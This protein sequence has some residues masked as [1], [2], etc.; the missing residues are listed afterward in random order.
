MV[1]TQGSQG[2]NEGREGALFVRWASRSGSRMAVARYLVASCIA[3][4][5]I[6]ASVRET[7]ACACCTNAGQRYEAVEAL[8]SGRLDEIDQLRFAA[9]AKLYTGEAD[10][11]MIKGV[12]AASSRYDLKVKQGRDRW[13]FAFRNAGGRTGTL[14]LTLPKSIAVFAVDPR[15]GERE[16][17]TG[18]AL[19]REWKLT[20][21]AVGTGIFEPGMG[22]GQRLT[23]VLQGHGNSCA[24]ASDFT[25]WTL[26]VSGPV[27]TYHLFGELTQP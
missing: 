15:R 2:L 6:A 8:D 1:Q 20:A 19:Y 10:P 9:V 21:R 24:S 11:D 13:V 18:P 22:E 23:L 17:G 27:A 14:T 4:A 12:A 5:G 7:H 26:V 25:H 16:G 3:L